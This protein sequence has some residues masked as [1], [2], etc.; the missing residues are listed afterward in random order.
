MSAEWDA[1]P[2]FWSTI[3]QRT[4]KY[5]AWGDGY[6]A[7]HLDRHASGGFTARFGCRGTLVGVLTHEADHDYEHGSEQIAEG[8]SWVF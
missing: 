6:D 1:V 8:A 4:L 7:T 2:G 3:G 5:A